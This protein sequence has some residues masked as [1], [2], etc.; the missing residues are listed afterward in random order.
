MRNFRSAEGTT[1]TCNQAHKSR[2]F[3]FEEEKENL[4]PPDIKGDQH[5]TD[6]NVHDELGKLLTFM[7]H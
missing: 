7:L 3:I 5:Q 6:S 4:C 2:R 1:D